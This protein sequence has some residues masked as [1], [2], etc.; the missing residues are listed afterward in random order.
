VPAVFTTGVIIPI[1]KKSTLNPNIS[2]HY[3]PVTLSSIHTKIVECLLIPSYDVCNTQFGF[4]QGRGTSMAC[5]LFTDIISYCQLKRSPLLVASLDAEKCFDSVCHTSL[6]AKLID[7]LP[8]NQ[9][10]FLNEWYKR[11]NAVIKYRGQFS[12]SFVITRGTR[13]GSV[14]SPYLF[15]IFID[16]LLEKL[17]MSNFGIHIGNK[18]YNSF[19]YADDITVMSSSVTGLQKLIDICTDYSKRWR[20]NFN[21]DKSKCML[22][23]KN[24]FIVEPS[25]YMNGCMLENVNTLEILGNIYNQTGSSS[26]HINKRI[27]KCRQSFY[28]LAPA[29]ILY[30][31]ASTDVQ[32]YLYSHICQPTLTYGL[33]CLNLTQNDVSKLD[34]VQGKFIKQCL[35]LSKR[36]H[37]TQLLEALNVRK[38]SQIY[39]KSCIS[40]YNRI[41]KVST[42]ARDLLLYSLSRYVLYGEVVPGTLLSTVISKGYSPVKCL[43]NVPEAVRPMQCDGHVDS[44][45]YLLYHENFI[46][47]YSEEHLLAHMLT[48]AF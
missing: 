5:N 28:S 39:E 48:V 12:K 21:K 33:D 1:L 4:R 27:A 40:L 43:F 23:G 22:I 6:F 38:V 3:R 32:M 17:S 10:L 34:S 18:L 19:A 26:D 25:L 13:Q 16:E 46:K 7:I 20:F 24:P 29:G 44:L 2:K 9:W 14:L 36:S 8:G 47:H 37:N 15:N 30:P 42:P 31:G 45:R 35:G 11:L 41:G